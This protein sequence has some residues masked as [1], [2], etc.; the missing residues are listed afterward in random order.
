MAAV[1]RQGRRWLIERYLVMVSVTFLLGVG[2]VELA[3]RGESTSAWW[4]AAGAAAITLMLIP[5]SWRLPGAAGIVLFTCLSNVVAGRAWDL[6]IAFGFV[7]ALEALTVV[8]LLTRSGPPPRLLAV[9]DVST[10]L[11]AA[12]GGAAVA[13][14][15]AATAVTVFAGDEFLGTA[16]SVFASHVSA[17]LSILPI[18]LAWRPDIRSHG[19]SYRWLQPVVLGFAV[20]VVFAPANQLPITFLIFPVL[21]WGAFVLSTR[22]LAVELVLMATAVTTLTMFGG[23]PFALDQWGELERRVVVQGYL[24]TFVI[25]AIYVSA[26][27]VEQLISS[28][29]VRRREE[30]LQRGIT[31]AP[32]GMLMLQESQDGEVVALQSNGRAQASLGIAL[33][34]PLEDPSGRNGP[35]TREEEATQAVLVAVR[36]AAKA[37]THE[38]HPFEA[39]VGDRVLALTVA[40][41]DDEADSTLITV[42]VDDV[43]VRRSAERAVRKALRD[44]RETAIALRA[45][46]RQREEFVAAVSHEL[47]TPITSILGFVEVL[48]DDSDPDPESREHLEI[49][50][51]NAVR[52]RVLVEDILALTAQSKARSTACN[53][54]AVAADAVTDLHR[55][56]RD[57]G[58]DLRLSD[59][60]AVFVMGVRADLERI[61]INLLSNAVKFTPSG[62][63]VTVEIDV[64]ADPVVLRIID[65]G[66]GI[67]P[68]QLSRV[69]GRFE[70]GEY[71]K[72]NQVAGVGLG[73]SM[74]KELADRNGFSVTLES[75]GVSGTT[76]VVELPRTTAPEFTT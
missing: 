39:R 74:V 62:G 30:L 15:T 75:D 7:N 25:F 60:P 47:R 54:G 45:A 52:L 59:T 72:A 16:M 20:L 66:P 22:A 56:A 23:G 49:I 73:L 21:M 50:E 11:L 19:S 5:R 53:L 32:I 51:R 33:R 48:L 14:V 10:L 26:A 76:A 69:F 24:L 1:T 2:A 40:R 46:D 8:W 36:A 61:V 57:H 67:P 34:G 13:G 37:G 43:T 6:S 71:A 55:T 4:P 42:H 28:E 70:R 58:V 3:A 38:A 68:D 18:A 17:L 9:R 65:T 35:L 29:R 12:A 64:N 41:I 27:R 63:S 44:E 31:G